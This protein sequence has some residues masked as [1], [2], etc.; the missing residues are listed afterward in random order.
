[1]KSQAQATTKNR[2]KNQTNCLT[3]KNVSKTFILV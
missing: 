3:N 2:H 1:M